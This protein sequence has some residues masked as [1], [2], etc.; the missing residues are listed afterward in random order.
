MQSAISTLDRSATEEGALGARSVKHL[1][2]P[3]T[4]APIIE[5]KNLTKVYKVTER[6]EGVW[7]SLTTLF[8]RRSRTIRAVDGI[9]FTIE[10]GE[11]VGY[12]GPNGAGKSTTIK[13]LTGILVPTS[14]ELF[15]DGLLP[16]R[17]RKQNARR[18][19]VVF[20]QRT[21]LWWDLPVRESFHILRK[22]YQV[23]EEDFQ[24]N[25]TYLSEVLGV[26][27][28]LSQPVRQ[29]SLGQR[30]RCELAAAL[31]HSPKILFLD[32]P[33]IGLDVVVKERLREA[34]KEI[35]R[36]SGITIILTTHDLGDIEEICQRIVIID[37]GHKIYDGALKDVRDRY[38]QERTLT[39]Q[40]RYRRKGTEFF[41]TRLRR[42]NGILTVEEDSQTLSVT[43]DRSLTSAALVTEQVMQAYR[44]LDFSLSDPPIEEIVKR[45]YREEGRDASSV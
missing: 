11:L 23:P 12:V 39:F 3:A 20:G 19:G 10:P 5:A 17:D 2:S 4:F 22:I 42:A 18:I 31:L 28:L 26:D 25:L 41:L 1:L 27:Q 29:L 6:G 44:V 9:N 8:S 24:A 36:Q 34:I 16:W 37:E 30:M 38:G 15:V 32:E 40:Y 45:I 35:N 13:M 14:G 21:Q 43:F 33:T 7:G